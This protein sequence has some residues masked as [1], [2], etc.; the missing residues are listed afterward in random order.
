M[1]IKVKYHNPNCKFNFIDKGE[2][3]DLRASE[4][5]HF[6]A[7]Y[8][9]TLNGG[10]D[11]RDVVFDFK[12]I[13]LGFA[14]ELPKE[15]EAVILPRSNTFKTW[16]LIQWNSEGVIDSSYKGNNDIWRFPAIAF[17]DTEVLEG[18]RI[19]QFRIQ[20]SQKASIWTKLKWLFTNKIEFVEVEDLCNDNRSGFGSTGKN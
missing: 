8:A 18:E 2:W 13:S 15:F 5:I 6:E 11:K 4:T 1:K 16:G 10:R 17:K 20:P 7:P 3:I 19:C 9:N 12:L 14:M